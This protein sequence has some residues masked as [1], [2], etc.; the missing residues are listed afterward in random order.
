M[1]VHMVRKKYEA[2]LGSSILLELS[3]YIHQFKV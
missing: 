3:M 2:I 1:P